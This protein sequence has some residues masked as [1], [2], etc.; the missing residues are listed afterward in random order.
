MKRKVRKVIS[1][2]LV[3]V[4][5]LTSGM[6]A[7]T[8]DAGADDGDAALSGTLAYI[9]FA[10][11]DDS[12]RIYASDSAGSSP[13]KVTGEGTYDVSFDVKGAGYEFV[14]GIKYMAVGIDNGENLFPGYSVRINSV[15]LKTITDAD[16]PQPGLTTEPASTPGT[17]PSG[18]PGTESLAT[19]GTKPI[20]ESGEE[21]MTELGEEAM[22]KD[23][24]GLGTEPSAEPVSVIFNTTGKEVTYGVDGST[25]CDLYSVSDNWDEVSARTPSGNLEGA[26][27]QVIPG[28][29]I[30][31]ITQKIVSVSVNF[32]YIKP[33][34]VQVEPVLTPLPAE[35]DN[36]SAISVQPVKKYTF[37]NSDGIELYGDA[38]ISA[39]VLDLPSPSGNTYAK[40]S[41]LAGADFSQGI[42]LTADIYVTGNEYDMPVFSFNSSSSGKIY[43]FSSAFKSYGYYSGIAND[44]SLLTDP[45]SANWYSKKVNKNRW[46][47][48]TVTITDSET[49]I[50]L[51]GIEIQK[52]N[53]DTE[54]KKILSLADDNYLGKWYTGTSGNGFSGK[55]DNVAI[56]NTALASKDIK[57]L[58]QKNGTYGTEAFRAEPLTVSVNDTSHNVMDGDT[59]DL[60]AYA[61]GGPSSE[62]IYQWYYM[63][64]KTRTEHTINSAT[65]GKIQLNASTDMNNR[66]Y[67]CQ[68]KSGSE[69]VTTDNIYI[70]VGSKI[71]YNANGGSNAPSM[72]T[73][74]Y[75]KS[76]K[77]SLSE[78]YRNGYTFRGW[79][80][81]DS[82]NIVKYKPGDYYSEDETVTLYAVWTKNLPTAT[83]TVKPTPTPKPTPVP[84]P[85]TII[86][87]VTPT[88]GVNTETGKPDDDTEKINDLYDDL[89]DISC[90]VKYTTV[91][92]KAGGQK[93]AV[94]VSWTDCN[95]A[96]KYKVYRSTSPGSGY[97]MV[98]SCGYETFKYTDKNVIKGRTY[99]YRVSACG[100]L[101]GT[102][103]EGAKSAYQTVK[104][105]EELK[106]PKVKYGCDKNGGLKYIDVSGVEGDKIIVQYKTKKSKWRPFANTG[107]GEL[108]VKNQLSLGA[109]KKNKKNQSSKKRKV[110]IQIRVRS[111]MKVNGKTKKSKWSSTRT[112]S[113]Y[114]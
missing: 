49:V 11:N 52:S 21:A 30:G 6:S 65:T 28:E 72:Q 109:D 94:K 1:F 45:Y 17:E 43:S 96:S 106:K 20:A 53:G 50:Y 102:L 9:C 105:K 42:T 100:T 110:Q 92:K 41:G 89:S 71:Y 103:Y 84:T 46:D 48:V 98:K 90:E 91:A 101:S 68:V 4:L 114:V 85:N 16:I 66:Y 40:I 35:D 108:K 79:S 56:Y 76:V 104:V 26:S 97:K 22:Q 12:V 58:S 47:T 60:A 44:N 39:G 38:G 18:T 55:I 34:K 88:P 57:K 27:S 83:P 99:Y 8:K 7:Y 37:N 93:A 107:F 63:D 2:I 75:G 29:Y 70:Y 69:K 73:K 64:A 78:P 36:L 10:D 62:Y 82:S 25:R 51:D 61:K 32:D 23:E 14:N 13:A 112:V 81:S 24:P 31:V 80:L 3:V 59:V 54:L 5:T 87:Y 15:T 19:P 86:I 95:N 77:L 111:S 67:Y 74:S 113:M 33:A